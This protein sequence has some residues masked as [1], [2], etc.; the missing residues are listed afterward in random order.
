M[1]LFKE[2]ITSKIVDHICPIGEAALQMIEK[3]EDRLLELLDEGAR[4]AHQR[5]E[6]TLLLM[7][8]Q[9]GILRRKL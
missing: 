1:F 4:E 3:E 8:Q 2:R 5:A 9:M 6:A 7:K